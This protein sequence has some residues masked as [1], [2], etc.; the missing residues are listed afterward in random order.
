MSNPSTMNQPP[1]IKIKTL[2]EV[3]ND[4]IDAMRLASDLYAMSAY[5]AER[6]A[7]ATTLKPPKATSKY[8]RHFK[9]ALKAR[10]KMIG[11]L[12]GANEHERLLRIGPGL[13]EHL[14]RNEAGIAEEIIKL[15][16]M[17]PEEAVAW[18]RDH[19]D[20]LETRFGA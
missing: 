9:I 11:S 14:Q 4:P 16:C 1:D 7:G 10:L 12:F 8:M 6:E 19:F 2:I 15:V 13:A 18:I 17:P 5:V 20:E 3:T